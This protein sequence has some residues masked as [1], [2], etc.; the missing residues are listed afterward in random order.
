MS[1]SDFVC[2]ANSQKAGGSCIAGKDPVN[3]TWVRP[4][5]TPQGG[6]WNVTGLNVLDKVSVP[7]SNNV[8]LN[9]QTENVLTG[10][11]TWKIQSSGNFGDIQKM[12]DRPPSIW[13]FAGDKHQDRVLFTTIQ[14]IG[15]TNSLYLLQAGGMLFY[16]ARGA[17]GRWHVK[18][19]FA[20]KGF[21]YDF[22]VT[23]PL[24]ENEILAKPVGFYRCGNPSNYVCVS[25]GEEYNKY[26]YKLIASVICEER[27][28]L[29][30]TCDQCRHLNLQADGNM[31]VP[32]WDD[33]VLEAIQQLAQP[34]SINNVT[35]IATLDALKV[36]AVDKRYTKGGCLWIKDT[37]PKLKGIIKALNAQGTKFKTG[38]G[39]AIG[40]P[41]WYVK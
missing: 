18:S 8:P 33:Q 41:G 28:V 23:D 3:K 38:N 6:A 7:M 21:L 9:H 5:P 14:R 10:P 17:Y 36:V 35:Y 37:D 2:L 12:L 27:Y 15:V 39:G 16:H 25:L 29:G 13:R 19:K 24:I 22:S 30:E 20:Y 34:Q 1:Y 32:T 26:C 11:G 4:V 31:T 40:G